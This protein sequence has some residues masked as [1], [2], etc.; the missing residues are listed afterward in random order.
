MV[1]PLVIAAGL[2]NAA[3]EACPP[4]PVVTS[5]HNTTVLGEAMRVLALVVALHS[6]RVKI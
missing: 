6:S 3:V 2:D 4:H 1:R 5:L